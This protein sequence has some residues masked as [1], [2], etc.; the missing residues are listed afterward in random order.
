MTNDVEEAW[1]QFRKSSESIAKAS[2]NE[3]LDTLAAQLNEVQ[4]DTKRLAQIVPKIM[5]DENAIDEAN[6]GAVDPTAMMGGGMPPMGGG[7]EGGMP[8]MGGDEGM[9]PEGEE[10]MPPEGALGAEEGGEGMPPA[11][12]PETGGAEGGDLDLGGGEDS[13]L[14]DE[15]DDGLYSDEEEDT[16]DLGGEP[17]EVD[18]DLKGEGDSDAVSVLK[19]ALQEALDSDQMGLV[20][21]I[22]D[23][24]AKLQGSS[25]GGENVLSGEGDLNLGSATFDESAIDD[26]GYDLPEPEG[27]EETVAE[28]PPASETPA[29]EEV[30]KSAI[31]KG[32][33]DAA[34]EGTTEPLE[35]VA[36]SSTD[37]IKAEV[38]EAVAEGLDKALGTDEEVPAGEESDDEYEENEEESDEEESDDEP[39]DKNEAIADNPFEECS[40]GTMKSALK[41]AEHASFRDLLSIKKS[42]QFGIDGKPAKEVMFMKTDNTMGQLDDIAPVAAENDNESFESEESVEEIPLENIESAKG[43]TEAPDALEPGVRT[44]ELPEGSEDVTE[45]VVSETDQMDEVGQP[46][47]A[48]GTTEGLD[49]PTDNSPLVEDEEE[50]TETLKPKSATLDEI[51]KPC[52]DLK[53]GES[54]DHGDLLDDVGEKK[55]PSGSAT[56]KPTVADD[57]GETKGRGTSEKT[58]SQLDD[59]DPHKG[60]G[61]AKDVQSQLDDVGHEKRSTEHTVKPGTGLLDDVKEMKK[62]ASDNGKHIMSMKELMSVRKSGQR[63]DAV[64]STSGDLVRPELGNPIRKTAT[65][66]PVRMGHGVDPR[67]VTENDWAEY[68]L[69]M[70]QKKL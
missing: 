50:I 67:K 25:V 55:S 52:Q 62:S 9:M 34:P 30:K 45:G 64:T 31:A 5:G 22:A 46:I 53:S 36:A 27:P 21:K 47:N 66:T 51:S 63:P 11:E 26:G 65:G 54:T 58:K 15:T 44:E 48:G 60:E 49:E 14:E 17:T 6:A 32:E 29:D 20:S 13:G 12:T 4:T 3:K 10:G 2:V 68:N 40:E 42:Y 33:L 35:Q 28:E 57:V 39:E 24:I 37:E 23:A 19:D 18:S 61:S 38:M 7:E 70:A 56:P 1:N 16:G 8:P 59:L 41:M 43:E 69:Y